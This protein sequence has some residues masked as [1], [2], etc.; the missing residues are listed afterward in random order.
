MIIGVISDTHGNLAGWQ[1]AW[2]LALSE[3]DIIIHCGDLLYHGPKFQPVQGYDPRGLAEALNSCGKPVLVARGNA[4]SDVDQLVV[5]VPIQQ[6]YLL[7]VVEGIRLLATHG[8]LLPAEELR[9]QASR[10]G[11]QVLLTG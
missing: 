9:S 5:E 8:H 7:A 10:W 11:V 3:A 4:D 1:R 2:E 6:P